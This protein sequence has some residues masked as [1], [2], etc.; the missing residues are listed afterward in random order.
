MPGEQSPCPHQD[1]S[2]P[3]PGWLDQM[4]SKAAIGPLGESD[5]CALGTFS[6]PCPPR[7]WPSFRTKGLC[8]SGLAPL[9]CCHS[10]AGAGPA[11]VSQGAD[12]AAAAFNAVSP[13][14]PS[15]F[16]PIESAAGWLKSSVLSW[17]SLGTSLG[18]CSGCL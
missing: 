10:G 14:I 12:R 16:L 11:P 7:G 2:C 15:C 8:P 18:V 13:Q 1:A 6:P 17:M 5:W 9:C 4:N 3:E